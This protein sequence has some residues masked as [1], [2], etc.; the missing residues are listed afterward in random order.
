MYV[1]SF[2][3]P[4]P[5]AKRAEYEAVAKALSQVYMDL[6]ATRVVELW[7]EDV[8]EG[9]LTSFPRAVKAEAGEIPVVAWIEYPDKAAR[10]ACNA[11]FMDHPVVKGMT[12][13]PPMDGK[14]MILGG[15]VPLLDTAK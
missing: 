10:D 1:E 13:M 2:V 8:S 14:R 11:A 12:E 6:G 15:F 9:T 3:M 4:V 7:P 5:E